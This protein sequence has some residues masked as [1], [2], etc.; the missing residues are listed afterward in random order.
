MALPDTFKSALR[1]SIKQQQSLEQA[2]DNITDDSLYT[3]AL[4]Q[5]TE[6]RQALNTAV[7]RFVQP[8][9]G[10]HPAFSEV[11]KGLVIRLVRKLRIVKMT[12]AITMI[13]IVMMLIITN[14]AFP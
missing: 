7:D 11:K 2:A 6:S 4:K 10:R 5:I 12:V 1:R 9:F 3:S 8:K 14:E 13:I